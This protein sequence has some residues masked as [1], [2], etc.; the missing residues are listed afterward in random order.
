MKFREELT[1]DE[2]DIISR[3][4]EFIK[5]FKSLKGRSFKIQGTGNEIRSFIYIDDF[6]DAFDLIIKHGK[7][8][9]I[10]NIGTSTKIKIRTLAYKI[11]KILKKNIILKKTTLAKGGTKIRVPNIKKIKKLGFEP[12]FNLDKGLKRCL[13]IETERN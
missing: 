12:K 8:Q 5:R 3:R 4:Q 6:L 10:Y 1:G 9:N 2:T 13:K 7:N 11:S